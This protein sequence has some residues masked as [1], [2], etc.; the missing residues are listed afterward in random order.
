MVD[1]HKKFLYLFWFCVAVFALSFIAM[2]AILY[3]PFPDKNREMA[4]N[5]QGFLQGS[6]IMSAVGF[7]LSG[8]IIS[9]KKADQKTTTEVTTDGAKVTTEPTMV[10]PNES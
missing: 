4:S 5:M 8:N 9:A 3:V 1:D 10:T 6:L 2:M 7:L